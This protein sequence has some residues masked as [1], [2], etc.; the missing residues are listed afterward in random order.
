MTPI[1]GAMGVRFPGCAPNNAPVVGR[2]QLLQSRWR[3]FDSLTEYQAPILLVA[4]V[5]ALS[6]R[7]RGFESRW[8]YQFML[9]LKWPS[10]LAV[11]R[12]EGFDSPPHPN[13]G[14]RG[15]AWLRGWL[16]PIRRWFESSRYLQ[17][18]HGVNEAHSALNR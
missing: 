4:K 15:G 1:D 8:E 11:T 2:T 9:R 12:T 3:V 18:L 5:A 14:Y 16:Q 13:N 7:R 17:S 6:R 10:S